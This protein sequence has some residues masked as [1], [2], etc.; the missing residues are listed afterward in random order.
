MT[1]FQDKETG[2]YICDNGQILK[3]ITQWE[4]KYGYKYITYKNRNYAVHRLIAKAFVR[5]RSDERNIVM[6]KDD[7]PANN[8]PSNLKWGTY[9][10]NNKEAYEH[11]LKTRNVEVRCIETDERFNSARDAARIKF[12]NPKRGD[13]IL[14]VI[15]NERGK[16]YG[17]HW[18]V[19]GR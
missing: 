5:G 3:P 12:G 4:D 15:K 14:A 17:Y 11:G 7:N 19:I 10:E 6:H 9:S 8:N 2:L 1:V 13:H 18:E 16:A